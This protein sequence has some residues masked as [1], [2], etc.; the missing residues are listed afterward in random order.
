MDRIEHEQQTNVLHRNSWCSFPVR[1]II[2]WPRNGNTNN[3]SKR[4]NN[5]KRNHFYKYLLAI[6][7]GLPTPALANTDVGGVSATANPVA[8]SSGS[9]TNQAIQVLQGP[10][11]TNTY[12]DGIS[13]QGSTLNIT[14]YVT[15]ALSQ[16]HPF[17]HMWDQP[18]YNNV[19][20]DDDGL[21][22]SPGEILYHIPTRTGM[23]N[24]SNISAGFSATLSI[25]M[26]KR[27]QE[28][29][30]AATTHNEYRAQLLANKRL[31][32][33]IARLKNCGELLQKGI[34]FHPRSPYYKVCAD[35]VVMNKNTIAPHHHPISPSSSSSK[36]ELP[37]SVRAADL[38]APLGTQ[39]SASSQ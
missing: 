35:V 31:D 13:C 12:G 33:E 24:N 30:E 32:F 16:Q 9:V 39:S 15:G 17:E 38:G 6:V 5:T 26:N 3:N 28:L 1:R 2:H 4:A 14:P 18:V 36:R 10:Y 19:D 29:C 20:G 27:Q 34:M 11:I 22:D 7:L 37:V 8:N 21:P 23:T 25:P